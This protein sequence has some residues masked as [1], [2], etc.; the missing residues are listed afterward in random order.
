[1]CVYN[2]LSGL[3]LGAQYE[4]ERAGLPASDVTP[5]AW[6]G[7]GQLRQARQPMRS[8]SHSLFNN[9]IW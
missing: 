1:M 4:H 7:A 8:H 2:L 9:L 6:R 3:C 5:A